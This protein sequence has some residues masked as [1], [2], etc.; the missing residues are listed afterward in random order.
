[1]TQVMKQP[2]MVS[3]RS[4]GSAGVDA[5]A[6]RGEGG[7]GRSRLVVPLTLTMNPTPESAMLAVVWVSGRLA[8]DP[9]ASPHAA[10][11]APTS[12]LLIEGFPARSLPHG[13]NDHTL[14]LQFHLTLVELEALE[15]HRHAAGADAFTL[16]LGVQAVTA[17]LRTHNQVLPAQAPTDTPWDVRHGLLSEVLPFWQTQIQPITVQIEPSRW[18]RDVLPGLGYDRHRLIEITLPPALPAH[19]GAATEWDNARR[20]FDDGRY[21]DVLTECRDL[22]AMWSR[23]FGANKSVPVAAAIAAARHWANGDARTP[24]LD[25]LWKA[26][27]DFVNRPH[28]PEGTATQQRYEAADA[29]LVLLL[30]AALSEYVAS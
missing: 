5:G 12:A 21:S 17:A 3:S 19:P 1:M 18:V 4:V 27:V 16:Y 6:I 24:F 13:P 22:L 15:R 20:A 25:H 23:Q 26:A 11:T 10:I 14:D 9:Y 2:I 29:R 8:T 28:H 30:T 7:A